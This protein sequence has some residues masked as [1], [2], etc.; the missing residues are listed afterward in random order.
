[1]I[2]ILPLISFGQRNIPSGQG[3]L[4]VDFIKLPTIAF[5]NDTLQAKPTK[6][7]SVINSGGNFILKNQKELDNWFKPEQLFLEYD[8]FILRVDTQCH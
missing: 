2:F 1:M 6:S 3:I 7:V 5:Y 8:I 4:K